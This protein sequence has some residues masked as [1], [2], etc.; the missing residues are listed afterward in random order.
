[1]ERGNLNPDFPCKGEY[2]LQMSYKNLDK[3][4]MVIQIFFEKLVFIYLCTRTLMSKSVCLLPTIFRL[5]FSFYIYLTF[6]YF[7]FKL[8]YTFKEKKREYILTDF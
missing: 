2:A 6:S 1:M 4:Q 7:F 3:I 5:A 8:K